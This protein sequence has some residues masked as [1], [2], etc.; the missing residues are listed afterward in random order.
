MPE[1]QRNWICDGAASKDSQQNHGNLQTSH[2]NRS[3]D[4][5]QGGAVRAG[6]PVGLSRGVSFVPIPIRSGN[7]NVTRRRGMGVCAWARA[8]RN[9]KPCEV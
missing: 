7:R 2:F 3:C 1:H 6:R 9:T 5:I 8:T 4:R